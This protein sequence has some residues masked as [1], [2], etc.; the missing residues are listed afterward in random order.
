MRAGLILISLPL[1][2]A[3]WSASCQCFVKLSRATGLAR[4]KLW[5]RLWT[6]LCRTKMA[7]R[8][9]LPDSDL[10]NNLSTLRMDYLS[11]EALAGPNLAVK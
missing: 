6:L 8:G 10:F 3:A 2:P 11:N 4:Q 7:I 5:N 9:W 1:P